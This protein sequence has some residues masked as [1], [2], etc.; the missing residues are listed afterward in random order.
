[1]TRRFA[2]RVSLSEA[3][4]A[5]GGACLVPSHAIHLDGI[6]VLALL[7]EDVT[8]VDAQPRSLRRLLVRFHQMRVGID[9]LMDNINNL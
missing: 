7:V 6:A 2:L 4:F 5:T 3:R 8:H 9:R 1:M